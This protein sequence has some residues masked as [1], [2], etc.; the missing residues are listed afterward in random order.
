M[1]YTPN[2]S[3][4]ITLNASCTIAV[5]NTVQIDF[6]YPTVSGIADLHGRDDQ[7]RER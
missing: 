2:D 1:T 7:Q 3:F 4:V 6:T 5:T